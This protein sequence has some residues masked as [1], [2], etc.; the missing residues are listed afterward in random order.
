MDTTAPSA[1]PPSPPAAT[2]PAPPRLT[3]IGAGH[4]FA[5]QDILRDAV[6]AMRPD[7]VCLELDAGRLNALLAKARGETLPPPQG[8]VYKRLAAFQEGVAASYGAGVGTEMLGSLQGAQ[9][10]GARVAL[11]DD[12]ADGLVRRALQEITWRERLRAVGLAVG[13]AFKALKPRRDA[14]AEV[15][16]ELA[17]YQENPALVLGELKGTFPTLHRIL[18]AERDERMATRIRK[19]LAEAKN[20]VAVVGD[21]HVG[22][23]L[24]RLGDLK[25]TVYRLA[26]VREGRLPRGLVA[27]GSSERVGFSF[28]V[29]SGPQ[30]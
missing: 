11:I 14:K 15:E 10:V 19:V 6:V 21:G 8:F 30:S 20:V 22:G 7:V 5:I 3:L 13:S 24:E 2:R 16:A 9:A 29:G 27:T 25:P 1:A 4:V 12:A 28:T 26:D 17:R 18:I 23:L